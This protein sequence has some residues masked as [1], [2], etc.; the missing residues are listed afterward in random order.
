[1]EA[2]YPYEQY[3]EEQYERTANGLK[4]ETFIAWKHRKIELG[5]F[6]AEL[7][8]EENQHDAS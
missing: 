5:K 4:E 1:M 6:F 2:Q 8:A 3:A 7:R